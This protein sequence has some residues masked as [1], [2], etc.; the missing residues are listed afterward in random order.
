[1]AGTS[2]AA[3]KVT[4]AVSQVWAANPGL[5]YPQVKEILKQTAVDLGQSGWDVETGSGLVDIAAAVELAKRTPPQEYQPDPIQSPSIWSGEDLVVPG[6]RAVSVSVPAFQARIMNAGYVNVVGSLRIRSGPGTNYAEVGRKRPGEEITFDA[7]ENNGRWV[8]DPHMPEGGSRHWYKIAGTN[9]W[10]SALYIDNTPER[11]AQERQRQDAIRRAEEE[12]R[13]AEEEVRRAEEEARR[14]EEE[15]RRIE[16]EA[17]RQAEEEARRR[18]EEELRRILEEQ[19]RQQEQLQAAMSQVAQKFGDLGEPLGSYVS[20]GVRVYQFATGQLLI[21]ADGSHSFYQ[22]GTELYEAEK[23]KIKKIK[24]LGTVYKAGNFINQKIVDP[25]GFFKTLDQSYPVLKHLPPEL[26]LDISQNSREF[27]VNGKGKFIL[28]AT[29]SLKPVA[30]Y[31]DDDLIK[32]GGKSVIKRAPAIDILLT[33]GDASLS[34]TEEQ[35]R[36]AQLKAGAM[37]LAGGIGAVAGGVFGFGAGALPVA[38]GAATITGTAIDSI[39]LGADLLGFGDEVDSYIGNSFNAVSSFTNSAV[40]AAKQAAQAAKEKAQ[41]AAEKAKAAYQTAKATV[42]QAQAAYQTFK[43][44]VQKKTTQIVQQSQ[45]RIKEEAQRIAQQVAQRVAQAAPKVVRHV[46][47]YAHKAVRAVS[48]V[49]NGAKQFVSN[50]VE[51]G[52]KIVKNVIETGKRV[53]ETVKKTVVN[54]YNTGKRVVTGTFN[55]AVN[56]VKDTFSGDGIKLSLPLDGS[57]LPDIVGVN[58]R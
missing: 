4:G 43:Q 44:E 16:E 24:Q 32:L 28:Q 19:R 52:K 37:L 38:V 26:V 46:A 14:A 9:H 42:Q 57:P 54:A 25:K 10:M 8:P 53:Y 21:Q 48:N 31:L 35:R 15:L 36:R 22:K 51:T 40:E 7:Y 34:Q 18:I 27:F 30:S 12:A 55:K 23:Q 11:A 2:V 45:Q 29:D 20:N 56:T 58:G 13:R 50:V 49:I 41:A 47:S 3:A 33:L 1:M 5:S 6:E 17:R 39:Y